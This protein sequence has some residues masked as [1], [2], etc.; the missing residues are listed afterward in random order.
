MNKCAECMDCKVIGVSD[1]LLP[2]R[3]RDRYCKCAKNRWNGFTPKNKN[4]QMF[5]RLQT[6]MENS[7]ELK[8]QFKRCN[9]LPK[10]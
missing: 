6:V 7:I 9:S 1:G 3:D 10:D 8:K 5:Y 2:K 4:K